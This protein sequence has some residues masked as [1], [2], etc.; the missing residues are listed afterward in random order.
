MQ[1]KADASV[2]DGFDERVVP[3]A[4]CLSI[5]G[6]AGVGFLA[7]YL[8]VR[9]DQSEGLILLKIALGLFMLLGTLPV[10]AMFAYIGRVRK[11]R[12]LAEEKAL[13]LTQ[14]DALTGL[15]NRQ[16]LSDRVEMGLAQAKRHN[17]LLAILCLDLDGLKPVNDSYG[18]DAGDE[19][20][21]LVAQ[22]L[23][24][25]L[26][27]VDTVARSGADEFVL[28][29]SQVKEPL[30]A[31]TV[32][33]KLIERI[34]APY[35]LAGQQVTIGTNIGIAFYPLHGYTREELVRRAG[36]A[37]AEAKRKGKLRHAIATPETDAPEADLRPP[38]AV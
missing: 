32:A 3:I 1:G 17:E 37:L 24:D 36:N 16:L 2:R 10:A 33:T 13:H 28:A 15:P 20:L 8:G 18:R 22:R 35:T 23:Q 6:I 34:S 38:S 26:R 5:V 21:R 9:A 25:T 19:L 27:A 14:H 29:L 12:Q 4:F 30:Y 11:Q 31:E 7:Y